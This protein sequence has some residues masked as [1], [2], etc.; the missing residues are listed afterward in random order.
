M[1]SDFFVVIR[2]FS[3]KSSHFY[4]NLS[5]LFRKIIPKRKQREI[6]DSHVIFVILHVK[7][8]MF[9]VIFVIVRREICDTSRYICDGK[10]E[11]CD[12]SR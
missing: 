11:I 9:N 5:V 12:T 6:C 10:R 1:E 2:S 3:K 7:F 8:V 4:G